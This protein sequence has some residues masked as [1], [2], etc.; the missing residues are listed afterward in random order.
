VGLS[1]ALSFIVFVTVGVFCEVICIGTV[2]ASVV[3]T[4]GV[5]ESAGVGEGL[6]VG[7]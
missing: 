3:V 2:G 7:G 1:E 4:V 5:G 6:E